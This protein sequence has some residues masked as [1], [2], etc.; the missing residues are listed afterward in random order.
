MF[1]QA[2]YLVSIDTFPFY[3]IEHLNLSGYNKVSILQ[4]ESWILRLWNRKSQVLI[5]IN[6]SL[7]KSLD[8]NGRQRRKI[9][10]IERSWTE[11]E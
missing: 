7:D 6:T 8:K 9:W 1:A 10:P 3:S 2:L 5:I 11:K 4:E